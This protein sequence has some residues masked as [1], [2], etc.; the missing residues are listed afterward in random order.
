MPSSSVEEKI[1]ALLR[2]A[3]DAGASEHEASLAMERAHELLLKHNLDM[4]EVATTLTRLGRHLSA[5]L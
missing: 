2:L 3:N 5:Y 4:M 1:R